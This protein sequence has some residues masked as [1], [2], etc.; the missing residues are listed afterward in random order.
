MAQRETRRSYYQYPAAVAFSFLVPF[1]ALE[2]VVSRYGN[3]A[4]PC[5]QGHTPTFS[6]HSRASCFF[7][8]F[9]FIKHLFSAPHVI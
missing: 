3:E 1:M 7:F 8:P 5:T 9:F 2:N 4:V 6:K